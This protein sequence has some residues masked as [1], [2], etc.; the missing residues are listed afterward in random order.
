MVVFDG[1][2]K[3]KTHMGVITIQKLFLVCDAIL[4]V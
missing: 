1:G 3:R 2:K 4:A